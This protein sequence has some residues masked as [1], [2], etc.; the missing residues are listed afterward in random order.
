[1]NNTYSIG[2]KSF[3]FTIIIPLYYLDLLFKIGLN[4]FVGTRASRF[5]IVPP[6]EPASS[7]IMLTLNFKIKTSNLLQ[8]QIPSLL[9]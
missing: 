9:F 5:H 1:L 2:N 6:L 4:E 8:M 3:S 7:H